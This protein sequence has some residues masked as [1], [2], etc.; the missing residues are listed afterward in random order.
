M[1]FLLHTFQVWVDQPIQILIKPCVIWILYEESKW[2][3]QPVDA[4]LCL[5]YQQH[6]IKI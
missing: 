2:I 3:L 1:V 6:K 4:V 5:N